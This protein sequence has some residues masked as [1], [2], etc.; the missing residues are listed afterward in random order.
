MKPSRGFLIA[1]VLLARLRTENAAV[2]KG[3]ILPSP[4]VDLDYSGSTEAEYE[5]DNVVVT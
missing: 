3:I 1:H 5:T 4:S 2:K